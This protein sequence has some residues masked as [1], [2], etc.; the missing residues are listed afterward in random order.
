V[1]ADLFNKAEIESIEDKFI[2][3]NF[4]VYKREVITFNVKHAM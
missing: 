2:S 4:T 3:N 1:I